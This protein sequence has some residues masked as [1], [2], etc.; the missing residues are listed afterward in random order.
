MVTQEKLVEML[1]E[2]E[3]E[4]TFTK[5]DGTRRVMRCTRHDAL[6]PPQTNTSTTPARREHPNQIR[7]YDLESDAWR[8]FMYPSVTNV[9]PLQTECTDPLFKSV[10]VLLTIAFLL[11]LMM[12]IR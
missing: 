2:G 9:T 12:V 5:K 11:S 8:S 1:Q 6:L 3:V 4:V 7:V 10:S